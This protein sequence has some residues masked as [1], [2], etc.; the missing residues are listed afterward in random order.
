QPCGNNP[1][2][3]TT[4]PAPPGSDLGEGSADVGAE[5]N[6]TGLQPDVIY[7]YRV[8]ASNSLGTTVSGEHVFTTQSQRAAARELPDGRAWEMVSPPDKQGAPVEAL[9]REGGLILAAENGDALTY[10]VD[11]ALGKEVG[12]NR[13]P[14]MQQILATRSSNGW[15]DQDIVTPNAN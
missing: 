14:E 2:A 15:R 11:G 7:H 8:I 1:E 13:S 3:C 12:G 5:A 4:T 10:V 9:T 6:L